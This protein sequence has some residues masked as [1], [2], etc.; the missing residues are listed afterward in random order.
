M[1]YDENTHRVT[2]NQTRKYPQDLTE[3]GEIKN[4]YG[5]FNRLV[6]LITEGTSRTGA[7]GGDFGKFRYTTTTDANGSMTYHLEVTLPDG[8]NYVSLGSDK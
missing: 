6:L 8:Q 1:K 2:Y 4:D 5:Y 7:Y 3:L